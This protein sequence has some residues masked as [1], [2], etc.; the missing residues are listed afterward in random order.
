L[1]AWRKAGAG[2]HVELSVDI[3]APSGTQPTKREIDRLPDRAG[4]QFTLGVR[5]CVLIY[6][7]EMFRH[8]LEYI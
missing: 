7:H 4:T 8:P 6:V 3:V 2:E 5:E 1:L